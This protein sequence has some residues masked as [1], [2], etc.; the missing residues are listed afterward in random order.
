M[1]DVGLSYFIPDDSVIIF[2]NYRIKKIWVK[3]SGIDIV[4]NESSLRVR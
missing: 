1:Y 3:S 4:R 2:P